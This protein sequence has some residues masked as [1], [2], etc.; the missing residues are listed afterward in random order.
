[1]SDIVIGIEKMGK[2]YRLYKRPMDKVLDAFGLNFWRNKYYQEFWALRDLDLEIKRGERLGII[3]RNGAG[4]STLLKII[5][6]NVAPTEGR[7]RVNGN[8]QALM[9]LGTG[10]HPEFTGRQNIRVSLS[11]QGISPVHIAEK[12]EEIIDFA[13]LEEFIDQPIKTYSAGM[14]A[15]LAFSTATAIEPDILII[16][17][18]LGAGDAYFAG[19]CLERMRKLTEGSGVTVLFVSH[20]L[21]SVQA[22]C[23]RV[24]WVDRG[25][26]QADGEPLEVIKQYS[27]IVR[28]EEEIRL[29]ARDLKISKKQ[30]VL[31]DR[32]QDLYQTFL[33][34][35]VGRNGGHPYGTHK[36]RTIRLKYGQEEIG[37]IDIG[38]PMDNN[39][40]YQ[41]HILDEPGQMDWG[42][43]EK[44]NS[45]YFRY[46]S[47]YNG[48]YAHAPFQLLVP[49][50]LFFDK[51]LILEIEAESD[52]ENVAVEFYN[53]FK[54]DYELLGVLNR[55]DNLC[56][57]ELCMKSIDKQDT[58]KNLLET[59][60]KVSH[61]S[62]LSLYEAEGELKETRDI[63][64]TSKCRILSVKLTDSEKRVTNV[65]PFEKQLKSMAFLVEF[66][67]VVKKFTAAMLVFSN[68]GS[69]ISSCFEEIE[70]DPFAGR[71]LIDFCIGDQRY[72]PGEYVISFAIY[73]ELDV[74]DNTREQPPI[75]IIDR[76][77]SFRIEPPLGFNLTMGLV[78]PKVPVNVVTEKGTIVKCRTYL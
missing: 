42:P 56:K 29:K 70:V 32:E 16:D 2:M 30:A 76:G 58:D 44:D 34:R 45:G 8:I 75:A 27:A 14:Y 22:L 57:F 69:L 37:R 7:V 53:W 61:P 11:Y 63:R 4:K 40:D 23:N 46:Y 52:G 1:M 49:K 54:K 59:K 66:L 10:F 51:V 25:K 9:E 3:G 77:I 24:I 39:K 26:V 65:F 6:G 48:K 47:D 12:E 71:L 74:M 19:K 41:H 67:C 55:N 64:F 35:L 72:G 5:I 50:N 20:D 62:D 73:D 17:E 15:R 68:S 21:G 33:F 28:K 43:S 31:I 38:A 60:E 78:N 36:I 18:V 13:E